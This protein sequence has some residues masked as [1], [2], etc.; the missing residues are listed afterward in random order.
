MRSLVLEG[1]HGEAQPPAGEQPWAP[2]AG[3]FTRLREILERV[4]GAPNI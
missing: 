4:E 1:A 3:E 2:H